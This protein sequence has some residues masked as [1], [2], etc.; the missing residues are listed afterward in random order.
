MS[1]SFGFSGD[2]IVQEKEEEVN[3]PSQRA[4]A[5]ANLPKLERARGHGVEELVS[6]VIFLGGGWKGVGF[7]CLRGLGCVLLV[8]LEVEVT[9]RCVFGD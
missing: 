3:H 1:F 9:G 2:D 7:V 5:L 6:P 4:T 8:C